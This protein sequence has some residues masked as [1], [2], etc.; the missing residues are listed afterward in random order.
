MTPPYCRR[1]ISPYILALKSRPEQEPGPNDMEGEHEQ[2]WL[3][4]PP[5][6][7]ITY[8]STHREFLGPANRAGP[9]ARAIH[10]NGD[11]H[12]TRKNSSHQCDRA[13]AVESKPLRVDEGT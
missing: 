5:S 10:I 13:E 9:T 3:G 8:V 12:D 2:G 6:L 1:S 11:D 7:S 4:G